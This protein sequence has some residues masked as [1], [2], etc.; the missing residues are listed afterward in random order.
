[1]KVCPVCN[2]SFGDELR[3]CDLDGTRLKRLAGS[4][5][6]SSQG[7]MWSLLGVGVLLGAM[8]I[9]TLSIIFTPKPN[10]APTIA[11]STPAPS[12]QVPPGNSL[13]AATEAQPAATAQQPEIVVEEPPPLPAK[14]KEKTQ[15]PNADAAL[16][17]VLPKDMV[18]EDNEAEARGEESKASATRKNEETAPAVKTAADTRENEVT[19]KSAATSSE[20]KKDKKATGSKDSDKEDDAKKKEDDKD[21]KKGGFFRVF[22][23]IFGKG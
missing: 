11:S 10:V 9:A 21:K 7:R 5:P 3:F 2:E 4:E 13:A 23:K 17:P 14:K 18:R 20:A 6:A 16:P 8:V 19:P 12:A 15:D 1:M 22:K